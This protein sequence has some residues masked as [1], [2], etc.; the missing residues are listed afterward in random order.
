MAPVSGTAASMAAQ[1][2]HEGPQQASAW[3]ERRR[4]QLA[5]QAAAEGRLAALVARVEL[6]EAENVALKAQL[7]TSCDGGIA[8]A[9]VDRLAFILVLHQDKPRSLT[10]LRM[11]TSCYEG[12]S[13]YE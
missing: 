13:A 3:A 6:L 12:S 11:C 2:R 1:P 10:G 4:R 5:A 8:D 7:Q 9:V